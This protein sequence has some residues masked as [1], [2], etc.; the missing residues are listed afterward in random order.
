MED[1]FETVAGENLPREYRLEKAAA[2]T[3]LKGSAIISSRPSHAAIILDGQ[4]SG[5]TPGVINEV[6]SG[7]HTILLRKDGFEEYDTTLAILPGQTHEVI[8]ELAPL[9]GKISLLVKPFGS[10]YIDGELRK[11]DTDIRFLTELPVGSHDIRVEHPSFGVWQKQLNIEANTQ[12]DVPIDFT[13]MVTITVTS[14]PVGGE[15]YV[16]HEFTQSYTPKEIE[17]RVGRHTIEVRREG[18]VSEKGPR[19]INLEENVKVPPLVFKLRK[20][21]G[22]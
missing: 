10:I 4:R 3:A 21:N 12:L 7:T 5:F 11:K 20:T 9:L 17:L 13:K 19:V 18:Y 8:G 16:D 15:I 1:D 14:V 22:D 6:M 2:T